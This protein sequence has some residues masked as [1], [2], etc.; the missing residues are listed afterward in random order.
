MNDEWLPYRIKIGTVIGVD[1]SSGELLSVRTSGNK[2]HTRVL[3]CVKDV[4]VGAQVV[5]VRTRDRDRWIVIGQIREGYNAG[6]GANMAA[7]A[8]PANLVVSS[9]RNLIA[10]EW[11]TFPGDS[12]LSYEVESAPD[13]GTGDPDL[14]NSETQLVTRGSYYIHE[15]SAAEIL[16]FRVRALRWVSNDELVYSAW[17]EW[18]QHQAEPFA[19]DLLGDEHLYTV[20]TSSISPGSL[21][22]GNQSNYWEAMPL[23]GDVT[24]SG[25]GDTTVVGFRGRPVAGISPSTGQV[26]KWDGSQWVPSSVSTSPGQTIE[27]SVVTPRWHADG[28]LAVFDEVDGVWRLAGDCRVEQV[29]VY[30]K[31]KGTSGSTIVDVE[32]ST[33]EGNTW[34][35]MFS[36][37]DR[38]ELDSA[39]T[40]HTA[41]AAPSGS[42][43][44]A[45]GTLLRMNIDQVAQGA[46]NLD[47]TIGIVEQEGL[48]TNLLPIM[49]IA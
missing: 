42:Q 12:T 44:L 39:D 45:T 29:V 2:V 30:L 46:R 40:D 47:V 8:P 36:P 19:H 33:D 28:P 17:S 25:G 11:E 18:M 1:L 31:N 22:V 14:A 10:V 21:I 20:G 6:S 7:L 37:A 4:S 24:L 34:T 26:Y 3:S 35:S 9:A 13:D 16:H 48:A 5:M 43:V 27:K 41:S 23:S 49:G 32:V 38:P 15:T